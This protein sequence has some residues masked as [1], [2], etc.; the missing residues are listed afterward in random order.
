MAYSHDMSRPR[1]CSKRREAALRS[2]IN[3]GMKYNTQ[4]DIQYIIYTEVRTNHAIYINGLFL[5]V[6]A[7]LTFSPWT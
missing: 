5:F 4:I 2:R 1:M 3:E 6:T 7:T